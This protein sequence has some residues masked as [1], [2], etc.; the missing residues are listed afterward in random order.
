[1]KIREAKRFLKKETLTSKEYSN[2][3]DACA[4]KS[5]YLFLLRFLVWVCVFCCFC[6]LKVLEISVG[7]RIKKQSVSVS[8]SQPKDF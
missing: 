5:L 8:E 4:K 1:M 3:L 2:P 7:L 6:F